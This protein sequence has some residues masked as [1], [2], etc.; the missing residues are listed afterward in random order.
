M[1]GTD[2][3]G[4][5]PNL[6][7]L[8]STLARQATDLAPQTTLLFVTNIRE[9]DAFDVGP[10]GISNVS[11]Y[12]TR[13]QADA[14]IRSFQN[15]GVTVRS[16][17]SE[18]EFIADVVD[19]EPPSG[20]EIVYTTAEGGSGLGRRALIPSL[21][22]LL[23]LPVLNSG[24][25]AC[26]LA[27]HKLHAN[28]VLRRFGVRVPETWQFGDGAWVGGRKPTLGARVIVKPAFESMCIGIDHES[29][30][31]VDV[32]SEDFIRARS[33]AFA[34]PVVV[35]EFVS[36]DEIGVPLVRVD[37][38]HALPALEVRRGDGEPFGGLPQTFEDHVHRNVLHVPYEAETSVYAAIQRAA[39]IAFDAL[40]MSGVGRV[41]F[42]VDADGRAWAFDTNE[43]PP[44]LAGT[45]YGAAMEK[46]GFPL[47]KML[48]VWL[49]LGLRE[50]GLIQESDQK[51][52]LQ[53]GSSLP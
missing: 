22:N 53:S 1:G 10:D 26:S 41:D 30:Q 43:S 45:A 46:L 13:D 52:R 28:A 20:P 40:G 48:A 9:G 44:P 39:V 27:R 4:V 47:E 32:D 51:L 8:M 16:F 36:G 49:G 50:A 12:Y 17:F 38:T 35:Q 15:L 23:G 33:E 29:I 3:S 42:R 19:R 2:G 11:Q 24:A 14:I 34:Q 6:V 7:E 31:V 37:R 21:C 25:H 18:R 5:D